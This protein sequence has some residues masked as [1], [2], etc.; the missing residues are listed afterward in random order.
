ML[1]ANCSRT[2]WT[3][4]A[5][6]GVAKNN[7]IRD[8]LSKA[9]T[10][11]PLDDVDDFDDIPI[12]PAAPDQPLAASKARA[13]SPAP[14]PPVPPGMNSKGDVPPAPP[15]PAGLRPP[16]P[17]MPGKAI[18]G[19]GDMRGKLADMGKFLS[20]GGKKKK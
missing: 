20:P 14:K 19:D 6:L 1:P 10:P 17:P 7:L 16:P 4:S 11:S 15:P 18:S 8:H 9:K 2:V 5:D 3:Q 13:P 12:A